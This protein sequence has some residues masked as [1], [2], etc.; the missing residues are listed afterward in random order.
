MALNKLRQILSWELTYPM[1]KGTFEDDFPIP[2]VG[3][4]NSLVGKAQ[5]I[6]FLSCVYSRPNSKKQW[7]FSGICDTEENCI[8]LHP[9][10]KAEAW[11]SELQYIN[12]V[13]TL[14]CVPLNFLFAQ[15][16][17]LPLWRGWRNPEF[18]PLNSGFTRALFVSK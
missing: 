6:E 7:W 5:A 3:Y 14:G 8:T 9:P 11:N 12:S 4:V 15:G 2:Q 13:G 1:K 16:D 10:S 17:C 18:G